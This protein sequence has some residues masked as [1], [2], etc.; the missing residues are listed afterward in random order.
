MSAVLIT[1]NSRQRSPLVTGPRVASAA[2][3]SPLERKA[4]R[5]EELSPKLAAVIEHLVDDMLAELE[6]NEKGGA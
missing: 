4:R 5:L 2:S 3:P 1:F 6:P